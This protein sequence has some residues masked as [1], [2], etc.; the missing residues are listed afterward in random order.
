MNKL[1]GVDERDIGDIGDTDGRKSVL[2]HFSEQ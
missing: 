2:F 1:G